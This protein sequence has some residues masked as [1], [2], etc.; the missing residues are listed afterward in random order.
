MSTTTSPLGCA[1]LA[2]SCFG[3]PL[4]R[5]FDPQTDLTVVFGNQSGRFAYFSQRGRGGSGPQHP[6]PEPVLLMSA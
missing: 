2:C 5:P 6:A 3:A 1:N 4:S